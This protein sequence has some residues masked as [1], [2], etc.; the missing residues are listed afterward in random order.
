MVV[1][2]AISPVRETPGD[3]FLSSIFLV[4]KKDGGLRPII[5]LKRL[6]DY[7]PHRHFK[8]EGIHMLKDLLGQEDWMTKIDLKDAYFAVPISE[9]DKKY[10]REKKHISSIAYLL[11]RHAL[12]GSL[13]R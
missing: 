7:V 11:G 8:M 13:P 3:G 4:P 5:N 12:L 1:K 9:P 10:L 6:N 2:G